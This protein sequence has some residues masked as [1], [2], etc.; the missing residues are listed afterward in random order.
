MFPGWASPCITVIGYQYGDV[1]S[2][3]WRTRFDAATLDGAA[4][5]EFD[6]STPPVT[7]HHAE[8]VTFG[9]TTEP[10]G[11]FSNM[12]AGFPLVVNGI[13]IRTS[14]ALYQACRFPH[15]PEVQREIIAQ[16]SPLV[17]KMKSR[18]YLRDSRPD[19]MSLRVPIMWWS[20]RVKLAC[21]TAT[22]APLLLSARDGIIVEES[23]ETRSGVRCPIRKDK[24]YFW[25]ATSLAY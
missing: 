24:E 5:A 17:A 13:A 16:A 22:F 23:A 19:F 20:L 14:E 15:H 1:M 8:S 25:A 4:L 11:C 9:K 21:N 12:A 3:G 18:K 10:W 6:E 7:Y 2:A